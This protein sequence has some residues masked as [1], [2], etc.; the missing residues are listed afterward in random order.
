MTTSQVLT[1]VGLILA[2]AVGPQVL[3]SRLRIPAPIILL[4]AGFTQDGV[5]LPKPVGVADLLFGS[6]CAASS[7]PGVSGDG[8]QAGRSDAFPSAAT[9]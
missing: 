5:P 6:A 7:P 9:V 3:A 1:G 2:L 4:P 8:G